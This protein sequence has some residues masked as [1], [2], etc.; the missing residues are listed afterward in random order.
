VAVKLRRWFLPEVPDLLGML[1][2]Q[3]A[4]TVEGLDAFAAWATGDPEQADR[5][6]ACEH[7][8]DTVKTELHGALRQA[9]V[10]PLEPE[11]LFALS[12][13]IDAVLNQAKDTVR[14]AEVMACPPDGAMA[15]MAGHLAHATQRLASALALLE[16]G[17]PVPDAAAA[18]KS[19]RR[20]EHVYRREMAALLETDDLRREITMR[21]LYRRCS[22]IG[23]AIVEVAERIEYAAVKER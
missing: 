12:R 21:E 3:A 2:R 1:E 7:R 4:I 19:R 23:D 17:D 6:R 9:F 16:H 18:I 15:R 22:R 8:A 11:D 14:E 5:V 10:T 13:G 20:L